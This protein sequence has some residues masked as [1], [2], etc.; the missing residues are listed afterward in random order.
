MY[1]KQATK[2]ICLK[3][4]TIFKHVY[5]YS[6]NS[7]E[8]LSSQSRTAIE[9]MF[10]SFLLDKTIAFAGVAFHLRNKTSQHNP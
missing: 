6:A 4:N 2:N 5:I 7:V 1:T 3:R 8:H 10:V 9:G